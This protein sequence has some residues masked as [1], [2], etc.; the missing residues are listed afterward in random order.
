MQEGERTKDGPSGSR[1]SDTLGRPTS[2]VRE[3]RICWE[4]LP[5]EFPV[6]DD[7]PLQI[8]FGLQRYGAHSEPNRRNLAASNA[9]PFLAHL[10]KVA[11][12]ILP[13]VEWPSRYD[14]AI[15]DN[16]LL[17]DLSDTIDWR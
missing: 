7:W 2:F 1:D 17:Y 16:I 14:M 6:K 10:R 11:E 3:H 12:W 15:S 8:G 9:A 4:V 13:K 5:E